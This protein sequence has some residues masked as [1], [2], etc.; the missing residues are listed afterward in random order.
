MTSPF[1]RKSS[2][3]ALLTLGSL[4][5]FKCIGRLVVIRTRFAAHILV[6]FFLVASVGP[7][8]GTTIPVINGNVPEFSAPGDV[9]LFVDDGNGIFDPGAE[10]VSAIYSTTD[11]QFYFDSLSP[12]S[13][14]FV[15]FGQ[16]VSEIVSPGELVSSLDDFVGSGES[17]ASPTQ[18]DVT[19]VMLANAIG[20][21]RRLSTSLTD[22]SG[23]IELVASE[24]DNTIRF[25]VGTGVNGTGVITWD[26]ATDGGDP[27]P[28]MALNGVD[29]TAAGTL[30]AFAVYAGFD[31]SSAGGE[32]ALRLFKD[33]ESS[34]SELVVPLP[35]NGGLPTELVTFPFADFAGAVSADDVD[36]V[37]LVIQNAPGSSD[38]QIAEFGLVQMEISP[39]F[40]GSVVAVGEP[41]G[42]WPMLFGMGAFVFVRKRRSTRTAGI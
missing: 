9:V 14:Y 33:G 8:F 38:G 26:G 11:G 28:A 6:G 13:H 18:T 22:G 21:S 3:L 37:Q 25:A 23:Y 19:S 7:L 12:D 4:L 10:Q 27:L 15:G 16:D 2:D 20:G 39:E 36:A 41:V 5:Q 32:F 1:G 34:F 24:H 30:D 29:L 31:S 35:I 42:S 17:Q 40:F